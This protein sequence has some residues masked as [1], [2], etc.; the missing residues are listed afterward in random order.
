MKKLLMTALMSAMLATVAIE[1]APVFAQISFGIRIGP[2]PAPRVFRSRPRQPGLDYVWIE[3]Y[4]YPNANGRS[5]RWHDGYWTRPPYRGAQWIGPRYDGVRFFDGY[6]Q[7][8]DRR[9]DR[10]YR[11]DRDRNRDYRR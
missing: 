6:W 7:G 3:G 5:Y 9:S 11:N 2:P 10:N 1:P 4:W 8:G